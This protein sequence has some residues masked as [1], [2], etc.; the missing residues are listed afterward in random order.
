MF[1]VKTASPLFTL[2]VNVVPLSVPTI[3]EPSD[4]VPV[5]ALLAMVPGIV[6]DSN[7]SS[8]IKADP[9]TPPED[10]MVTITNPAE[11]SEWL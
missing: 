7:V 2:P 8:H 1:K 5:K 9:L 3:G 6:T 11:V 4:A 10:W